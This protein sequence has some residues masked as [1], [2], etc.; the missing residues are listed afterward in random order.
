MRRIAEAVAGLVSDHDGSLSGEH[1][2][3]RVRSELLP[4][5][6]PPETIAAFAEMKRAL[7]PDGVLNPG[8]ISGAG[9]IDE[10][11]RARTGIGEEPAT[12]LPFAGGVGRA[13]RACNGNGLCRASGGAMCPTH[14]ALGD[15]RH[16][17]R[18]RAVLF[19]AA[20]EGH[21]PEGLADPGLHE[22]LELC[23]G[24]KA[25]ARE[26][27]AEV[28]MAWMK[29]ESL[30][31]RRAAG[32][33]TRSERFAAH[34]AV[35]LSI[36]A[37]LP[38]PLA[39]AGARLATRIAGRRVPTPRRWRPPSAAGSGRPLGLVADTFTRNL[40]PEIGD[41]ALSVLAS[42]A[43]VRVIDPGCCGRAALSAG[44]VERARRQATRMLDRLAP[45]ALNGLPLVVLEP[46]CWSMLVDDVPRLLSDDPRAARVA[47]RAVG[48]E[49]A[50]IDL[51]FVLSESEGA[52]VHPHCHQRALGE[53]ET[54]AA[55]APQGHD[56][57]AGCCGMAGAFGYLHP[58][59]SRAVGEDRL[60]PAARESARV[61]AS[62]TSCRQQ[63]TDLTGRRALHPAEA[64][65]ASESVSR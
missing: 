29:V 31:A 60:A 7:D 52:L 39:A 19:R 22:A 16:A 23:L 26:C 21:L 53:S 49:R 36:A 44:D 11:L 46:S 20:V 28:D 18:G 5:M 2:D 27:P 56:S 64:L 35:A 55:L 15:E 48:F 4:M 45:H 33:I 12:R 47:E 13:A 57:G 40:H 51:G 6:Y 41:A 34:A 62:G 17:T 30:A 38:R 43:A 65:A 8:V 59:I 37:R 25:C 9:R 1:G 61:V 32:G 50:A 14:Q 58:E 24:C 10:G 54:V 63:I 42:R 3:G